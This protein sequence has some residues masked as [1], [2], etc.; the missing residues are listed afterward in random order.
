MLM[1][2]TEGIL[3]V[4]SLGTARSLRHAFQHVTRR[5]GGLQLSSSSSPDVAARCLSLPS[6]TSP[7]ARQRTGCFSRL[8]AKG[9]HKG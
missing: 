1:E 8:P 5:A 9:P 7:S 4:W 6:V 2:S 3:G